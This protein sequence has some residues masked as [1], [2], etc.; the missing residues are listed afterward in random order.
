M[1]V[2]IENQSAV[3][4]LE[5]CC[6]VHGDAE[7]H[8]LRAL[9]EANP[10]GLIALLEE[11]ARAGLL[12]EGLH[13]RAAVFALA[14][15]DKVLASH[16][17]AVDVT[18]GVRIGEQMDAG[19]IQAVHLGTRVLAKHVDGGGRRGAVCGG[20][21][22]GCLVLCHGR[23]VLNSCRL[24]DLRLLEIVLNV[25][26]RGG[27]QHLIVLLSR[28]RW[29]QVGRRIE[30]SLRPVREHLVEL[31]HRQLAKVAALVLPR[32]CRPLLLEQSDARAALPRLLDDE[33]VEEQLL[34]RAEEH[35]LLEGRR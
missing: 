32:D 9:R 11:A 17:R 34:P 8:H 20:A 30:D 27:I 3:V 25:G 33:G 16:S 4:E 24:I 22:T 12:L 26:R 1:S 10:E 21:S 5:V 14:R 31:L 6:G 7:A 19:A 13:K 15:M 2:D 23:L 35:T 28:G 29:A 18:R